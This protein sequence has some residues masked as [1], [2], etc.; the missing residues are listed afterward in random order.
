LVTAGGVAGL[1]LAAPAIG[2]LEAVLVE[3]SVFDVRL[4][5]SVLAALMIVGLTAGAVPAWRAARIDP[6]AALRSGD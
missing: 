5:A 6:V 1:I 3:T 2:P 4:I